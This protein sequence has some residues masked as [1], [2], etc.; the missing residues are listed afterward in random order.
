MDQVLA[1][2]EWYTYEP[3]LRELEN[4]EHCRYWCDENEDEYEDAL[5]GVI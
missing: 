5:Y 1:A 3:L 2:C 4:D